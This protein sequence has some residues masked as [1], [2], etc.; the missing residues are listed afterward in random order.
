MLKTAFQGFLFAAVS[1]ARNLLN[2]PPGAGVV[3]VAAEKRRK[4]PPDDKP[5][6]ASFLS[7]SAFV[8]LPPLSILERLHRAG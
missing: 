7:E 8:F 2:I 5:I 1:P 3:E 4:K 6:P